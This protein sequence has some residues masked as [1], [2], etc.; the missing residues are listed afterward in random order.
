MKILKSDIDAS[1]NF[2]EDSLVGFT[3]A[4]YVRR[5]EPYFIAYLSSQTGC[6][7]GCRFCHL[8]TTKQT[9]FTDITPEEYFTQAETIFEHYSKDK[10]AQYVHFNFMARGEALNNQYLVNSSTHILVKLGELAQS[11][12]LTPK[13]NIST[14]LPA[15]KKKLHEIFP[16][17]TP[18]IYYSI[19][20]INESWRRKWMPAAKPALQALDEIKTYQDLSKKIVK[21]HC[22]FI[23]GQ[24]DNIYDVHSMLTAI[25]ERGIVG[26]F[27]I[28]RYNPYSPEQGKETDYNKI[29]EISDLIRKFMPVKII[30]RLDPKTFASCGQFITQKDINR[31]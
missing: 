17:V 30:P 12:N 9:K 25:N 15:N 7:R 19:Y 16:I 3:E 18:T 8:T 6:N 4:R 28:V 20:S 26:Q 22:A 27:N 13:F 2:I 21:F 29:L 10:V 5:T 24:N 23:E 11:H 1:V 31:E 14:I